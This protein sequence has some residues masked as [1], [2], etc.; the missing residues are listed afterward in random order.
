MSTTTDPDVDGGEGVVS[1]GAM[2]LETIAEWIRNATPAEL[3]ELADEIEALDRVH[4]IAH[5]S[6][7][8]DDQPLPHHSNILDKKEKYGN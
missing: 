5:A 1:D 6:D 2:D 8:V 7:V 3:L 4:E